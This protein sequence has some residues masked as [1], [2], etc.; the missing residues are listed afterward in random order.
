MTARRRRHAGPGRGPT[1]YDVAR[2]AGVSTASASR[3]RSRPELV[4]EAVHE[5]VLAAMRA[6]AYVPNAAAQV[7]SG[8]PSRLIGAVIS[9]L[10]DPL[11]ACGL[12]ALTAELGSRGVALIL[13]IA[14]DGAEASAGCVR[15][16][17]A[18]GVDAIAFGGDAT[19]IEPLQMN[20]PRKLACA[21]FDAAGRGATWARSGFERTQA[22]A[23]AARYLRQLG[24]RQIALHAMGNAHRL[25]A[26]RSAIAG[27]GVDVS[28]VP[29]APTG[30]AVDATLDHWQALPH[31]P[32]AVI[33]GSDAAAVAV[34]HECARRA[35]EV[36]A[37]L[38]V[39]GLGDT[40]L[41]RQARPALS[42]LR[43]PAREAGRA[44]A[45]NLLA[46]L[47]DRPE[48]PPE[49]LAKLVARESTTGRRT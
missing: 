34:L 17:I 10:D 33:C 2:A 19:P 8:R 14:G 37:R 6:L 45:H 35:I 21:S 41:A 44:L 22:L 18:R 49:L 9:A 43:V 39:V 24:H 13:A 23:L 38:S 5:R 12:E 31:P 48:A 7:L 3:A 4:S 42:T 29:A 16:L 36:P 46:L 20:P 28:L 47:D 1:L 40:E 32:T 26:A 27:V 25:G 15:A 11:T 30:C